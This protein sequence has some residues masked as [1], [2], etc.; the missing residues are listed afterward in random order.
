MT[1]T[2]NIYQKQKYHVF[3]AVTNSELTELVP[4]FTIWHAFLTSVKKVNT[5]FKNVWRT[6]GPALPMLLADL[7]IFCPLGLIGPTN[8]KNSDIYMVYTGRP[9]CGDKRCKCCLQ[10]QHA[11]VFHS[12]MTGKEYKIFCNVNC[13]TP[14]VVYLLDCHV[15]RLQYVGESVQPF[16][17]RMNGHRSDLTKKTLLPVSQHFVSLDDFGR[18]KIYI[19]DHNPRQNREFL[20]PQVTNITLGRHKQKGLNLLFFNFLTSAWS[21]ASW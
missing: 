9:P 7:M 11:Q 21:L 12:K 15:C 19:I 5:S 1:V 3:N 18:S 4:V 20:D 13:K 8:F 6:W 14:N 10:L 2:N 16:N 17:K